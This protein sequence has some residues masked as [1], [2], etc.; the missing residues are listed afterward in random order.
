MAITFNSLQD[1]FGLQS[2]GS[3][4]AQ[5]LLN[6][7][8]QARQ[9]Q[10]LLQ[11]DFLQNALSNQ[12]QQQSQQQALALK[13]KFGPL[14][15]ETLS[16]A[17]DTTSTPEQKSQALQGYLA[18]GGNLSDVQAAYKDLSQQNQTMGLLNQLGINT[19]QN[20]AQINPQSIMQNQS[21]QV[22]ANQQMQPQ[23]VVDVN[24]RETISNGNFY[25]TIDDNTAFALSAS[26]NPQ[27]AGIGK[28]AVEA[29]KLQQ[30]TF[31]AD[32]KYNTER[33][34]NFLNEIDSQRQAISNKERALQQLDS[35]LESGETGGFSIDN[36]ARI[37]GRPELLSQSG[38]QLIAS[39]K[40]L[41][42]SN[43]GRVGTRPNQW[44]EQQIALALPDLGKS[45]IANKTL[46]EAIRGE[47]QLS[48]E[49]IRLADQIA[50]ED[51]DKYGYERADIA[52][53]VDEALIPIQEKINDNSAYRLR[54]LYEQEKGS[55]FL[56][57]NSMKKVVEGTPLTKEMYQILKEKYQSPEQVI[58][59]ARK[60]GYTI[61]K[62]GT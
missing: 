21:A 34:K 39:V 52:R 15:G 38:A 41:L 59:N 26:N 16:I 12:N 46:G 56:R 13:Q 23:E 50:K 24:R 45:N 14:L 44:I 37:F 19:N 43:V 36:I 62:V 53:R 30:Q 42:I 20:N 31:Q 47:I 22:Q 48:R 11:R 40:E 1:P 60:L 2:A 17:Y 3:V 28:A 35:A 29:K 4:L 8:Q 51:I 49:R 54:E 61:R 27:L 25:E 57:K 55:S 33:S 9:Q 32:R 6:N 5:A 58:D 10:N 18:A 7:S